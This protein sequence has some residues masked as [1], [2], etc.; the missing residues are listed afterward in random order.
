[1]GNK[2]LFYKVV[3]RFDVV[4]RSVVPLGIQEAIT[5]AANSGSVTRGAATFIASGLG[6]S[7]QEH[8]TKDQTFWEEVGSILD[9]IF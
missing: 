3:D 9:D 5:S 6:A 7:V 8:D 1:M 4:T 2:D